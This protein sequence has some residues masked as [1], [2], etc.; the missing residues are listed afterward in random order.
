MTRL[1]LSRLPPYQALALARRLLRFAP[2]GLEAVVAHPGR[3]LV[4]VFGP[5]WPGGRGR[6]ARPL[7]VYRLELGPPGESCPWPRREDV[8]RKL[9]MPEDWTP[10]HRLSELGAA[11]A[12]R[13]WSRVEDYYEGEARE[14][15]L[16]RG[17][18]R[19]WDGRV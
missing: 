11:V 19:P 6:G 15:P 5:P 4:Y 3:V 2:E 8:L 16:F 10:N 12:L 18:H 14:D 9:G 17:E 1:D 13:D 7:Q